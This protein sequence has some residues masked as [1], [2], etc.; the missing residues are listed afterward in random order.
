MTVFPASGRGAFAPAHW[1]F[2]LPLWAM[3]AMAAVAHGDE[4][5]NPAALWSSWDFSPSIMITSLL[6][7]LVYW[8]GMA[9]RQHSAKAP[10]MWRHLAYFSGLLVV[11]LA[12]QSP[13]DA[14]ADRLF[15]AHQVQHLC[16]RML[17]PMLITV[18]APEG[19]L[20]AG[21]PAMVKRAIVAP[22]VSNGAVRAVF[23]TLRRAPVAFAVFLASLYIWQIPAVHNAAISN[24]ALHYTM[25]V[26]MLAAGLLFFWL[27]FDRRDPPEALSRPV[28]LLMLIGTAV[29]NSL[30]GSVTTLKTVALYTAYGTGTRLFGLPPLADESIGGYILWMPSSMMCL[31]AI[32][33]V[34]YALGKQEERDYARSQVWT[35]SNSA[36]LAFPQTAEELRIKTA[37]VNRATGLT[38]ALVSAGMFILAFAT[39]I[40]LHVL[41]NRL[42]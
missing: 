30:I 36:A 32:F 35:P 1:L 15:W 34:L 40:L 23:W 9:K 8:R 37:A 22:L 18:A 24:D 5:L 29:S 25:H 20:I 19:V 28:R 42:A 12:L 41:S 17:G 21:L 27:M 11:Y 16:L 31:L 3:G 6:A 10:K 33:F 7:A 13:L 38:L 14:L 2:A 26:T 4:V 39:V